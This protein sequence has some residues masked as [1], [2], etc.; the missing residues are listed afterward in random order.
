M[1]HK[2]AVLIPK[3]DL[4]GHMVYQRLG[5]GLTFNTIGNNL[6]VDASTVHRVVEQFISTGDLE[7]KYDAS[8]LKRKYDDE[9]KYFIIH[10]LL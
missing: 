8:S 9:M 7:K 6:G 1:N 2:E 4:R 10:V 3:K 5:L